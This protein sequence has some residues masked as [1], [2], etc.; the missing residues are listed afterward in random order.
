MNQVL[1]EYR[2]GRN[3][4]GLVGVGDDERFY[5]E[6]DSGTRHRKMGKNLKIKKR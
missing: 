4:L 1:R 5:K 2:K 3:Y 6:R